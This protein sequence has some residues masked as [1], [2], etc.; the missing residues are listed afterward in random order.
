MTTKR[1]L[2]TPR[3]S[4]LFCG[5]RLLS[6][7]FWHNLNAAA[8]QSNTP[9]RARTL[10]RSARA[11]ENAEHFIANPPTPPNFLIATAK[12]EF[13]PTP[14]KQA[15]YFFLIATKTPIFWTPKLSRR[16]RLRSGCF[17]HNLNRAAT[18][19]KTLPRANTLSRSARTMQHAGQFTANSPSISIFLI[20]NAL[21]L[22]IAATAAKQRP[23]H[24][25]NR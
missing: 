5:A 11:T 6:G 13:R 10:S 3:G 19:S 9:P 16:A 14:T 20:D 18:R 23:G 17:R 21:R 12:L 24:V 22:E 8:T 2:E 15:T 1:E 7:R 25:S 4:K